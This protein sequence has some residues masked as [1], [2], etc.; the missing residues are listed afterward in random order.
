[1]TQRQPSSWVIRERSTGKII[2]EV[3]DPRKIEHLNRPKYQS[4]EIG[5]YLASINGR[6][7]I[8]CDWK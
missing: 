3:T 5:N 6:G 4:A 8:E 7:E 2:C 1:M